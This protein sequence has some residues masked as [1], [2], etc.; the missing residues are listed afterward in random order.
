MAVRVVPENRG[1][2]WKIPNKITG[3]H[4]KYRVENGKTKG[5]D[6]PKGGVA[7]SRNFPGY[8]L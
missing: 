3:T 2:T 1:K 6:D 7:V 4:G 8:A 5:S